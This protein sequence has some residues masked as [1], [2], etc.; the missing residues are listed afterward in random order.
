M[1]DYCNSE[2]CSSMHILNFLISAKYQVRNY[3]HRYSIAFIAKESPFTLKAQTTCP[4]LN[5]YLTLLS[6]GFFS[7]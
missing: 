7:L 6:V 4:N 1:T 2:H 3:S 5:L